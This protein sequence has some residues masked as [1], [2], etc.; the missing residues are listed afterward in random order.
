MGKAEPSSAERAARRL[1][2][3]HHRRER[4]APLPE[5][6][7]PRTPEEAYAIQDRF[8]ALRAQQLGSIAGYKIALA[9][10]AMRRLVGI[11]E[12]QAGVLLDS[13]LHR[14]PARVRAAD[15][16]H[17]VVEFEIAVQ[18]ALDLPGVD[19]PFSRAT[20]ASAVRAVMPAI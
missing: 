17:L 8:V 19:A 20:V 7:A 10:E 11:E 3:A 6:L 14:A 5:G 15:Y 18:L 4:F 13:T 16:V 1:L 2:A 9:S 12:P